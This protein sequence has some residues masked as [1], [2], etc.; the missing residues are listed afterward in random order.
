MIDTFIYSFKLRNAYKTNSIIYSLKSIP[1]V[2]K[3]LPDS[4]YASRTLKTFANVISF[5][6]ELGS[7][8]LGKLLYLLLMVF[9][10]ASLMKSP[11]HNTFL[12]IFVFLTIAGGLLNTQIFNPTKDKYYAMFLMRMDA[13]EYT[14]TNYFYFLLKMIIGF[15]PFTL[16]FGR[17]S[18]VPVTICLLM[19]FFVCG[20]KLIIAAAA[21]YDSRDG[22]KVRNENL[23]TVMVWI[24]IFVTIIAAYAPPFFGYALNGTIFYGIAAAVIAAGGLCLIYVL[25]FQEYRSVY[26]SLLIPSNFAMNQSS[27]MQVMQ[28]SYKK[29]ITADLSQTSN[30]TGYKYFN[31]LFMKRH[32]KMLTRT[33]IML[34]FAAAAVLCAAV[35]AC[36][37]SPGIRLGINGL[38]L[39]FLPYF[40]F[41]MYLMNRGRGITMALFMNCDHSMLTYRFYRQPQAI[42][43]LFAERL[44][45]ITRINL[46]PA[47]VI[48]VGLPLLLF[49]SGGTDNPVNYFV[50]F[51]SIVAMSIFFSVH[52]LVMYYLLQPYNVA[53][54][55]KSAVYGIVN[56]ITYIACYIAIGKKV[57]T[58]LFGITISAF[59]ILYIIVALILA[60]RLAPKTFRLRQ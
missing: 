7:I 18:K 42:L 37:V 34:T 47:L 30:Q 22:Q 15:L 35:A 20:I 19:P 46:M 36:L 45:Y 9:L 57:P 40:L 48:A 28:N 21:L 33:A 27:S 31:E 6:M 41:V 2:K 54:E 60:Y 52:T 25:R 43:A 17:F 38:M 10:A 39:S 53:M 5:F 14:L 4:L 16:L 50:L 44:K 56:Y 29:K 58:I 49:L 59:C 23:P 3:L 11:S 26:R 24:G 51:L 1:L 8:F 32:S 13:R 55:S 12:H